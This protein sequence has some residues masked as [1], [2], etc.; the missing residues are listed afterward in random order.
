MRR[1]FTIKILVFCFTLYIVHFQF[2]IPASAQAPCGTSN[3]NARATGLVSSPNFTSTSGTNKFYTSNSGSGCVI[4]PKAAFTPYKLPSFDDLKSLYYAQAKST[5]SI[6]KHPSQSANGLKQN[7][8]SLS[9]GNSHIYHIKKSDPTSTD[10]DL[11]I[12]GPITPAG[13]GGTQ[14]GLVFVEGNLYINT[15]IT[16]G[17]ENS[18][19]VFVVKG[20][21]NILQSVTQVDAILISGGTICTAFNGTVCPA[22]N[23]TSPQLIIN[24]SLISLKEENTIKFKRNLSNNLQAAEKINHQVKYLVLLRNTFSDT[25]QRWSEVYD[26]TLNV[27]PTPR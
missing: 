22:T 26:N 4:D 24:G 10:G 17:T 16:Y 23:V 1:K 5:S 15:N 14:T 9:G 7:N 25:L 13:N 3:T 19:L 6:N 18:G 27:L 8:I 2:S 12:D 21:I 20:D 11:T